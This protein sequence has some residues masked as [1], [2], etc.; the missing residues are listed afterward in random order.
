MTNSQR[1]ASSD[2]YVLQLFNR[3]VAHLKPAV[4]ACHG[5]APSIEIQNE[6]RA[7]G[8]YT[9]RRLQLNGHSLADSIA[10]MRA[11]LYS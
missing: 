3:E 11:V 5:K 9:V 2:A 10:L 7:L 6:I 8:Q 4:K 1:T